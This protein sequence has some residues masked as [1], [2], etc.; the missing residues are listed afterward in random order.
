M[1]EQVLRLD[2]TPRPPI[3]LPPPRVRRRGRLR[4]V[5]LL[6]L[7]LAVGLVSWLHPWSGQGGHKGPPAAPPQAIGDASAVAGDMPI[8]VTALGT[9]TPLATVTVQTQINGQLVDVGFKEGQEVKKGDFLAQI[10]PRPYQVA[11]AQAQGTLAH[12]QALLANARIDLVRYQKL[13]RQD[14]I[15]EQQVATQLSLVQQ[16]QGT[17]ASD[18]AAVDTQKLNLTYCHIVAPVDGRVGLRLVDPGNYVQT[19]SSTGLVVITKLKPISVI[20]SV[21]EDDIPEIMKRL[22]A[23]ATLQVGAYNRADT[24]LIATGTLQT[25]DNQIDTTTGTVKIRASFANPD[26]ALFPNQFVNVTLLVDTVHNTVLVPNAAIQRGAP[27]TFVF[28]VNADDTV[29]VRPVKIGPSD[30]QNTSVV[31]GLKVGD[32][33]V[34]DGADRLR[35]GAKVFVPAASGSPPGKPGAAPEAKDQA[36]G[37]NRR[38]HAAAPSSTP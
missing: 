19:S 13:N 26:E 11:L 23:G 6:L 12:D 29:S 7:V 32:K 4:W 10:D 17:I 31:Q 38:H 2:A 15:A 5:V 36:K 9:V 37:Q 14:S 30:A 16:Y 18:Q 24:S 25:V 22:A 35:D 3:T 27:G 20:F 8:V 33:V 34:I 21:P 1:D 28:L